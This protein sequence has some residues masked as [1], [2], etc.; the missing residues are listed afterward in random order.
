MNVVLDLVEAAADAHRAPPGVT[1][2]LPPTGPDLE[3]HRRFH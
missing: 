3:R 2:D 1:P